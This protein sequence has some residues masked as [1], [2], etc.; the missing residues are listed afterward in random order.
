MSGIEAET[1]IWS[2]Q[3]HAPTATVYEAPIKLDVRPNG[4]QVMMED[5]R[6]R[7]G[8]LRYTPVRLG[9]ATIDG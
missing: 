5:G 7:E 1:D 3:R 2:R 9:N 6:C 8:R 4:P